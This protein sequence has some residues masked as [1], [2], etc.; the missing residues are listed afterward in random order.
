MLSECQRA[1]QDRRLAESVG[2]YLCW[3]AS[4]YEELQQRLQALVLE[5]RNKGHGRVVHARLPGALAE[6][7]AAWEMFLEFALEVGAIGLAEK[8]KLVDRGERAFLTLA[9]LQSQYQ[10]SDPGPRFLALANAALACGRGHVADRR[11]GAPEDAVAWGWQR[12][13]EDL[14]WAPGGARIGW[15]V[16]SNLFL[17]P[18]ASYQV[19]QEQAGSERHGGRTGSAPKTAG[20]R[21]VGEYR[22]GPENAAG[23]PEFGG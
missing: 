4:H 6:L 15:V 21:S 1:G 3:V 9:T 20:R 23:A 12:K 11:G 17:E 10:V 7:Q 14:A 19:A 13:S 18:V 22:R 16:G 5:C 8:V 2:G